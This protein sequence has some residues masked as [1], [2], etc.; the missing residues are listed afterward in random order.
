MITDI[1][2]SA[3]DGPNRQEIDAMP[4]LLLL[5]FGASWCAHCQA[6]QTAIR[7][8]VDSMPTLRHIKI[9]DGP[10]QRLGRSYRVKLWPTLILLGD[11]MELGRAVRPG[12]E[13]LI[14]LLREHAKN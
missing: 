7:D 5:E 2:N 8:A 12:P 10:G 4:G 13:E 14:V 11:G 6:A 9:E 1:E 3:V